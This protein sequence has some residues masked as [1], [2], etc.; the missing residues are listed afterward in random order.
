MKKPIKVL[1]FTTLLK[2]AA[3]FNNIQDYTNPEKVKHVFATF[4]KEGDFSA[5]LEE[6]GAK[7]Y[8]LDVT[9]NNEDIAWLELPKAYKPLIDIIEKEE[10]DVI[11]THLLF[12]TLLGIAVAKLKGKKGIF[13]RHHS[14]AIHNLSSSLK[15]NFY[16]MIER[17]VNKN[18]KHIIAPSRAVRDI[19]V[20]KEN[21]SAEKVSLIPYGQTF[22][23]FSKITPEI[24]SRKREEL[25]MNGQLSM[26]CV[27]RLYYTK[28][29]TYLFEAIAPLIKNGLKMKLYLA[30]P[31]D[32]QPVLEEKL[33][34]LGI[35]DSVEFLGFRDDV[36]A[37]IASADMIVHPSLE[38]ALS[39][40]LIE[41]LML[42]RPIVATDISG[43]G[44]TLGDGKYG[45][46]VK[47]SDSADL[48]KGIE[49][50]IANLDEAGNKAK[51]GREFLLDYMSAEK[52]CLEYEKIYEAV[53]KK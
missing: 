21:V 42:E 19:L 25:G 4:T 12:P 28:G 9:K 16:L 46:L 36:L 7:V 8:K 45:R 52:A 17:Y 15:R 13:T 2:G 34:E 3:Y 44:D 14:D 1:H 48:R 22:E 43:A 53:M 31:G 18:A 51:A 6:R 40:S 30:G 27:S 26:V 41:S 49:E 38:D 20:E 33:T 11:H 29:H 39:Q 32:Y 24:V 50:A 10:I 47:P 5:Q 23:R 35:A 37:I